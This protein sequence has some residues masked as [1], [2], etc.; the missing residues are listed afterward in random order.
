[1]LLFIARSRTET[2][3]S[4]RTLAGTRGAQ[5]QRE[6]AAPCQHEERTR[7]ISG[8]DHD[9]IYV[10][11]RLPTRVFIPI[12]WLNIKCMYIYIYVNA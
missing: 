4:K 5:P 11:W 10:S 2:E 9:L 7:I 1:M 12:L 6:L 8:Q 3:A